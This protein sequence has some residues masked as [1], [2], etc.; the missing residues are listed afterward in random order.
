MIKRFAGG[1][2]GGVDLHPELHASNDIFDL[3]VF[4]F[5]E[6]PA[7][8]YSWFCRKCFSFKSHYQ[9]RALNV[10]SC[11]PTIAALEISISFDG[12]HLKPVYYIKGESEEF[13]IAAGLKFLSWSRFQRRSRSHLKLVLQRCLPCPK[14]QQF[15]CYS[16]M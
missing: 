7:L 12:K 2:G 1:G 4:N 3:S 13:S 9:K 6:T 15:H 8:S 14:D 16:P 11:K 10:S 5:Y